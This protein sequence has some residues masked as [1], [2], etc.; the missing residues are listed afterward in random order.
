[1][2]AW[3]SFAQA[4]PINEKPSDLR[5]EEKASS[6]R[7][8]RSRPNKNQ[9]PQGE[10]PS[11]EQQTETAPS[12]RSAKEGKSAEKT[13]QEI[14]QDIFQSVREL[15]FEAVD[16][17]FANGGDPHV[18]EPRR[19][20]SLLHETRNYKMTKKL[21]QNKAPPNAQN[22]SGDT[23]FRGASFYGDM[24]R[25]DLLVKYAADTTIKDNYGNSDVHFTINKPKAF[26]TLVETYNMDPCPQ[27]N[28]GNTPLMRAME[29]KTAKRE[30]VD[31]IVSKDPKCRFVTNQRK[32]NFFHRAAVSNNMYL[33]EPVFKNMTEE[34]TISVLN[35]Q[36]DDGETGG[37]L[38]VRGN[39][40]EGIKFFKKNG[41]DLTLEN[42][43]G[44]NTAHLAVFL[45]HPTALTAV[46]DMEPELL[47]IPDEKGWTLAHYA[48]FYEGRDEIINVL[49]KKN[50]DFIVKDKKGNLP[51]D[52][53]SDEERKARLTAM[54][55]KNSV[56][57]INKV[58]SVSF[59]DC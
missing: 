24:E 23:P 42:H 39:S 28:R 38:A 48:Y 44:M 17:Y 21:L 14:I 8:P 47:N 33:A 41:G 16:Q 43:Q 3:L 40:A 37:H 10:I 35:A 34:E 52:L 49:K 15:D 45:N 11:P 57:S 7:N 56:A 54:D 31:F 29:I 20:N 59:P 25:M 4:E 30:I 46:L 50:A 58:S 22:K 26:K 18:V 9:A 36:N 13:R 27:N 51:I 12:P 19:G 32:E 6:P 55:V 2:G 5:A 53:V 1:M